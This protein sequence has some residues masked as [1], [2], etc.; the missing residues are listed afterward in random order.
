MDRSRLLRL[1]LLLLVIGYGALLRFDALTLTYGTVQSPAWLRGLQES[2]GTTTALRPADFT[3]ERWQGRYIS[4]PYTYLIF[5][6]EMRSFYAAH[7]RE[8]LFPFATRVSLRLL[9]N[10]D[11]AVSFASLFFSVLAIG[12]TFLLGRAAFNFWVGLGAATALA[13][14]FEAVSWGVGGWR[15]DAFMCAVVLSAWAMLRMLRD[16]S[17]RN[18]AI[19]G[20]VAAAACLT[21]ITSLSFLLP[22]LAFLVVALPLTWRSRLRPLGITVAVAMLLAGPYL[23]NCWRTFGDPL[24]AINVH[25]DV[26]R[27]AEGQQV[28]GAQTASQY[29]RGTLLHRPWAA[30]DTGLQGMTIYPFT[31]KWTGFD[32]WSRQ[33][34]TVLSWLALLGLFVFLGIPAGRLLLVV[35]AGSLVPYALT[36]KLIFDWRFTMHAY[37]FFLLASFYALHETVVLLRPSRLRELMQHRPQRGRVVRW[38]AGLAFAAALVVV[39]LVV[40]PPRAAAETLRAG[41]PVSFG[42]YLRDRIY[43]DNGW[44]SPS[45]EG[46]V[47]ARISTGGAARLH[48]PLPEVRDYVMT[49]RMD[50]FPAPATD[51]A[52]SS[53]LV[54]VSL[55][56]QPVGM[57]QL[58]WDPQRI[59]SYRLTIPASAVRSGR[60][61]LTLRRSDREGREAGIRFWYVRVR[62]APTR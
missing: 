27:A 17:P 53:S 49:I 22:A 60:N 5:A 46:N 37:P 44:S 9:D 52:T 18:A 1:T 31:N 35:L 30:I 34:G 2:R 4:D 16:P 57:V 42:P 7:H 48:L 50:P 39:M 19:A 15:D 51:G 26:Y 59:G 47:V 13:I 62:T 36:W 40:V 58:Q 61:R 20:A 3:W 29:I 24:Y 56:N 38:T 8:P 10:Q 54:H 28:E 12:A 45:T 32:P 41:E 23:V 43:F 6:R 33:L 25:A 14:E 55:N 21:R 11:I